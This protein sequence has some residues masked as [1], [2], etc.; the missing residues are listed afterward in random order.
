MNN[1]GFTLVELLIVISIVSILAVVGTTV[2]SGFNAKARDSKRKLDVRAIASSS[3]IYEDRNY[4]VPLAEGGVDWSTESGGDWPSG[5]GTFSDSIATFMNDLPKDPLNSPLGCGPD[6]SSPCH[7]T[8][9]QVMTC[10]GSI[11]SATCTGGSPNLSNPPFAA[12]YTYLESCGSD[13]GDNFRFGY[14][15]ATDGG[16]YIKM[17]K[18]TN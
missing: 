10:K 12:V 7:Y 2:F 6:K 11:A 4:T 1:K 9:A 15:C 5:I 14:D 8:Y 3:E 17:V 13:N 18:P 16:I